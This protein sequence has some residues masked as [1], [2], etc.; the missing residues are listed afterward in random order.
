M[1]IDPTQFNK[2]I[3]EVFDT[4]STGYACEWTLD[5][6]ETKNVNGMMINGFIDGS[7]SCLN[8]SLKD[9]DD[10]G[11]YLCIITFNNPE[12]CF[13]VDKK[14]VFNLRI[15]E[16]GLETN[17]KYTFQTNDLPVITEIESIPTVGYLTST[18]FVFRCG[19]CTDSNTPKEELQYQISYIKGQYIAS[20]STPIHLTAF[21]T[22][23]EV[24]TYFNENE[25]TDG[26]YTVI[27]TCRDKMGAE[28]S[29]TKQIYLINELTG[30]IDKPLK[31]VLEDLIITYSLTKEETLKRIKTFISLTTNRHRDNTLIDRTVFYSDNTSNNKGSNGEL[32]LHKT[33]PNDN[34]EYCTNK[35][36]PY[37]IS[38]YV[39]CKCDSKYIGMYCHIDEA[40]TAF[41][42]DTIKKLFNRLQLFQQTS[43]FDVEA[44]EGIY[45]LVNT[46][47]YILDDEDATTLFDDVSNFITSSM[48]LLAPNDFCGRDEYLT[49]F[50]LIYE[51]MINKMNQM[52]YLN[53]IQQHKQSLYEF[54]EMRNAQLN[55]EQE[56]QIGT[57]F[58]SLKTKIEQLVKYYKDNSVTLNS[59]FKWRLR[60]FNVYIQNINE[61]FNFN[62]FFTDEINN[63]ESYF[64]CIECLSETM[65]QIFKQTTYEAIFVFINWKVNPYS[66]SPIYMHNITSPL[67]SIEIYDKATLKQITIK[68]CPQGKHIKMYFP[69]N[70]YTMPSK[71][72]DIREVMPPSMQSD[73]VSYL[74]MDPI[75][76]DTN[77]KVYPDIS[78]ESMTSESYSFNLSCQYYNV[79][80]NNYSINGVEYSDY[81]Y[82]NYIECSSSHF[83]EFAVFTVRTSSKITVASRFFYLK[84]YKV[85]FNANNYVNGSNTALVLFLV[86]AVCYVVSVLYYMFTHMK[87]QINSDL[88]ESLS[89]A[90][91]KDVFVYDKSVEYKNKLRLPEHVKMQLNLNEKVIAHEHKNVINSEVQKFLSNSNSKS[92]IN[93]SKGGSNSNIDTNVFFVS[94]GGDITARKDNSLITDNQTP[95]DMTKEQHI[96]STRCL[97]K[98]LNENK[99][100]LNV[101]NNNGTIF[102][103]DNNVGKSAPPKKDKEDPHDFFAQLDN[104]NSHN[105]NNNNDNIIIKEDNPQFQYLDGIKRPK[106]KSHKPQSKILRIK[107]LPK[108]NINALEPETPENPLPKITAHLTADKRRLEFY[109]LKL[110]MKELFLIN[111]KTRHYY[112]TSLFTSSMFHKKFIQ[113]S[114]VLTF[115]ALNSIFLSVFLTTYKQANI[116]DVPNGSGYVILSSLFSLLI[117]CIVMN[118]VNYIQYITIDKKRE[119]YCYLQSGKELMLLREFNRMKDVHKWNEFVYVI[120]EIVIW[121]IGFYFSFG[122]C[123]T[124]VKQNSS[125]ITGMAVIIGVDC[126]VFEFVYEGVIVV[127]YRFR[128]WKRG[129]LVVGEFMNLWRNVK[130][131]K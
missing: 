29:I 66:Y 46:A 4:P 7:S 119:M 60:N 2:I 45:E 69:I 39:Y 127:L 113:V 118:G 68:T 100:L 106:E 121:C 120:V 41:I 110:T 124:Y 84:H 65:F 59:N 112:Y 19:Q 126:F 54:D 47:I 70:N 35:G 10:D 17:H 123:A 49:M 24:L 117:S 62:D 38:N 82:N 103:K 12:T 122:F 52:K 102:Y 55:K 23:R 92:L 104:D 42:S 56:T 94:A 93:K 33:D 108:Q 51:W 25:F 114:N 90:L 26:E 63:Y 31:D 91:I 76:I 129:V 27:C 43:T 14:Y 71:I 83:S 96:N 28:H 53:Y 85:M 115:I 1:L 88:I 15:S 86:L 11:S 67:S 30:V 125:F 128:K 18:K 50:N 75:Y 22:E 89:E 81:T 98:L 74:V 80:T 61:L 78:Y 77:G 20:T 8:S 72:N 101:N 109:H 116:N 48:L 44:L 9:V 57:L 34:R 13:D 6:E 87:K 97:N 99:T 111:I 40:S 79:K 36:V 32:Y 3:A 107:H 5:V 105:N 21:S 16:N 64:N 73:F 37:L 130:V 131:L 58:I 95:R